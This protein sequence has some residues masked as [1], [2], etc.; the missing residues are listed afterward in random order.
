MYKREYLAF[1]FLQK[2][3][4]YCFVSRK[5]IFFYRK[6]GNSLS[7]NEEKILSTRSNIIKSNLSKKSLKKKALA[8]LPI[9]GLNINPGSYVL[10]RLKGKTLVLWII[11][12]LIKAKN[13]SKIVV[14]SPDKNILS[15]LKK[16]YKSKILT[17]KRD[18]KLGGINIDCGILIASNL[19]EGDS[20]NS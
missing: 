3:G 19:S 6:H 18:E 17:H 8:I 5:G 1:L 13:I 4:V 20:I 7:N 12:S 15:F 2:G 16:K 11:D 14:T 10:K 9:R